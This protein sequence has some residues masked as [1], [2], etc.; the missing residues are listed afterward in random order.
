MMIKRQKEVSPSDPDMGPLGPPGPLSRP[1]RWNCK[2][3]IDRPWRAVREAAIYPLPSRRLHPW[4]PTLVVTPP[5]PAPRA[6]WGDQPGRFARSVADRRLHRPGGGA[7]SEAPP[8]GGGPAWRLG[9]PAPHMPTPKGPPGTRDA[10]ELASGRRG[11]LI[12]GKGPARRD[13]PDRDAP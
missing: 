9:R 12:E 6:V 11:R 8:V 4:A 7:P 3:P 10:G 2:R 5:R 13:T 1:L